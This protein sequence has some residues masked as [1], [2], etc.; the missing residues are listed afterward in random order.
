MARSKIN[1]QHITRQTLLDAGEICAEDIQRALGLARD[2]ITRTR[3][4]DALRQAIKRLRD[5]G[6]EIRTLPKF[7]GGGYKLISTP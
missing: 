3:T 1:Y 5:D 7:D 2:R 4:Q 6:W